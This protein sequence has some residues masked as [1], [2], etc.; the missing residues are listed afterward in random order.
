MVKYCV[1]WWEWGTVLASTWSQTRSIKNCQYHC[2]PWRD[3]LST[4]LLETWGHVQRYWNCWLFTAQT[5]KSLRNVEPW[6]ALAPYRPEQDPPIFSLS[7]AA[8]YSSHHCQR[9]CRTPIII[10]KE[11]TQYSLMR[12]LLWEFDCIMK[13][14]LWKVL[15]IVLNLRLA[16]KKKK[17]HLFWQAT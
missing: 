10:G 2:C 6:D 8:F 1:C 12:R 17:C 14:L 15:A 16:S 4:L 3:Q 7:T 5:A 13:M 9:G 11:I